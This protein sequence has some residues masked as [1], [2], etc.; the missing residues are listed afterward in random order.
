MYSRA[1][2]VSAGDRSDVRG[3]THGGARA[4][5][6]EIDDDLNHLIVL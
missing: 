6:R 5:T 3:A 4:V 1:C 2:A